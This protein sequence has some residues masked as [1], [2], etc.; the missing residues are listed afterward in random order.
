MSHSVYYGS[1]ITRSQF[2]SNNLA[3]AV[4]RLPAL[5]TVTLDYNTI[6]NNNIDI[7]L[8]INKNITS[9]V[10]M[11]LSGN[12]L[13]SLGQ[14]TFQNYQM[15]QTLILDKNKIQY[16]SN[17]TFIGLSRLKNLKITGNQIDEIENGTFKPL[18]QL[19]LL[20]LSYN[21]FTGD[22]DGLIKNL[23]FLSELSLAN[24]A[25]KSLVKCSFCHLPNL[26]EISLQNNIISDIAEDAFYNLPNLSKL[27]LSK[28][29][30]A[31]KNQPFEALQSLKELYLDLNSV[32][33]FSN[34]GLSPFRNLKKLEVLYVN[35]TLFTNHFTKHT[36]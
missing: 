29:N 35:Q 15:L 13:T 12:S 7:K 30:I 26:T 10:T 9:L 19:Q 14:G 11:D 32:G 4:G 22:T 8:L 28:N 17:E 1:Q 6:G 23:R 20:K 18:K 33:N 25:I 34:K 24:N 2:G 27:K 5:K 31:I 16:L 21:Q 36:N 3:R